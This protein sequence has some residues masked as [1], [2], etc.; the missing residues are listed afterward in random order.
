[1]TETKDRLTGIVA[2]G[3]K[4]L[5]VTRRLMILEQTQVNIA[6]RQDVLVGR[7]A[8]GGYSRG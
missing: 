5:K 1:M 3:K 6:R 7:D 4:R 8:T 2:L